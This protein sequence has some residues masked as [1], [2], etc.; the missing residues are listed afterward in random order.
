MSLEADSELTIA[1]NAAGVGAQPYPRVKRGTQEE[2]ALQVLAGKSFCGEHW[3]D[4][5]LCIKCGVGVSSIS[6]TFDSLFA[7]DVK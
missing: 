1:E 4:G 5:E 7:R 3:H 2:Q 6:F